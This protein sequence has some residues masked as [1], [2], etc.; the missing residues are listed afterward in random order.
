MTNLE[1]QFYPCYFCQNLLYQEEGYFSSHWACLFCTEKYQLHEVITTK[2][3]PEKDPLY[4]HIYLTKKLHIRLH[5]RENLTYIE[6]AYRGGINN[7][8]IKMDGFPITLAN[9]KSKV[10]LY[11]TF[12]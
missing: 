5:L 12:L 3:A 6:D 8:L 11:L 2:L 1:T 10:Q 9:V 4:A 7:Y